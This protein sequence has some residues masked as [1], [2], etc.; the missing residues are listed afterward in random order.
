MDPLSSRIVDIQPFDYL[1]AI[2]CAANSSN[3]GVI[4]MMTDS[5]FE[6][7]E[8]FGVSTE[9][10]PTDFHPNNF[11]VLITDSVSRQMS[12]I[13]VPQAI[14]TAPSNMGY[15]ILRPVQF[16]PGANLTLDVLNLTGNSNTITIA[17]RGF[18]F[19]NAVG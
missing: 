5:V 17:L 8:L 2:T 4:T 12:N 1:V 3:T 14:M 6:F 18:K 10:S 13:R 11:S 7:H 16:Q 15:R 9:D 19:F